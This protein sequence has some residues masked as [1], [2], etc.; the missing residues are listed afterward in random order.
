MI[1]CCRWSSGATTFDTAEWLRWLDGVEAA[2]LPMAN[3]PALLRW[4]GDKAYL[5]E[6]SNKGVA[7]VETIEVDRLGEEDLTRAAELFGTDELVVKPPVSA[8]ASG[9]HR[10]RVGNAIP[11]DERGQRMLIQPFLPAS[12]AKANTASCSLAANTATPS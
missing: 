6:L 3:P 7:A 1:W 9:T 2:G 11:A 12:R 8:G 4:N 10:I 5:R